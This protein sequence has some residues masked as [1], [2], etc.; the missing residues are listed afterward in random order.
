MMHIFDLWTRPH[1]VEAMVLPRLD[2]LPYLS[3]LLYR[4]PMTNPMMHIFDLWMRPGYLP[5]LSSPD[6]SYR[7][8]TTN[9]RQWWSPYMED[10]YPGISSIRSLV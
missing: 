9:F 6:T 3:S 5:Y 1:M 2:Y 8:P 4:G 7:C 10:Y